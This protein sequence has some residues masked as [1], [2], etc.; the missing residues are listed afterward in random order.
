MENQEKTRGFLCSVMLVAERLLVRD[1]IGDRFKKSLSFCGMSFK[2]GC[3]GCEET[4]EKLNNMTADQVKGNLAGILEEIEVNVQQSSSISVSLAKS[5]TSRE[6]RKKV[7]REKLLEVIDSEHEERVLL[8]YQVKSL[9]E[10][11]LCSDEVKSFLLYLV[12]RA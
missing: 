5:F 8:H 10:N 1:G 2:S 3:G 12:G 9:L 6:F 11:E 4:Q 7:C